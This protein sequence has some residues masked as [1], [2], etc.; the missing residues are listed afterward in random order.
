MRACLLLLAVTANAA[1][2]ERTVTTNVGPNRLTPDVAI[3]AAAAPLRYTVTTSGTRRVFTM[4]GG[5]E[6]LRFHDANGTEHPYL[7]IAPPTR[8]PEW[9]AATLLPIASTKTTSGFEADFG[10]ATDVDRVRIEGIA[11]PFLKRLRVEGSGDRAHWTVLAPDATLFDLPDERLRNLDVPF[12]HGM[13]RY[14]RVTWD[15]RASARVTRVGAVS[16]RVYDAGSAPAAERVPVAYRSTTGERGKSRY[17]ISLPGAHLPVIA[18]EVAAANPNVFRNATITEPR[19]AGSTVQPV[20]LGSAKL[21]RTRHGDGIAEEMTIPIEFPE[22]PDLELAIDDEN[23]PP[24]TIN[25][26]AATLAPLPTIYFDSADGSPLQASYGN[27]TAKAPHYDLEAERAAIRLAD[28]AE[29]KWAENAVPASGEEPARSDLV[30][31]GAPLE[32]KNFQFARSIAPTAPGLTSLVLDADVLAHSSGLRDVRIVRPDDRQ[33]PYLVERRD[34]PLTLSVRVP[35]RNSGEGTLS[36]YRFS[37]PYQSLP[38]GTRLIVTTDARV[39]D[40]TARLWRPAAESQGRERELLE[41]EAWR[42]SDSDAA[43]PALT[44]TASLAGVKDVELELDEGDNTPLPI[45]GAQLY[46]PS[47]AVRFISPGGPLTLLYGNGTSPAPRYDLAML[48]PRL[49]GEPAREISLARAAPMIATGSAATERKVFW[50]VIAAAVVA[51][52]LTL[53]RLLSSSSVATDSQR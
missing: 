13:F 41:T 35:P 2:V 6:D 37:L 18:I 12:Q 50:F 11:P 30:A 27:P 34:A 16:A 26:I 8:K 1:V 7:L 9:R 22:G 23:N 24:L 52:L 31:T 44:F 51:L 28:S 10:N 49:F 15:D 33:V 17:R 5:L 29:A 19:L 32:R 4:T 45:T 43:P 42:S 40:R 47:F 25:T 14:L 39:F 21:R 38:E 36:V 46:I 3:L 48:A 53:G 20:T